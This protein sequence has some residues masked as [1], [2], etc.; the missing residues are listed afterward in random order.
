M[1]V[2]RLF[3]YW[4]F[5]AVLVLPAW[6]LVGASV[7]G[8]SGWMVVG[9]FF[10]GVLLGIGLL[11]VA[12]L[13]YARK[14]V[15]TRRAVSWADVGALT[16]WHALI[17]ALGFTA[18]SGGLPVLIVVVG[19]AAFWFVIWEFYSA[20]RARMREMFVVIDE[21]ARF[22][23]AAAGGAAKAPRFD[24]TADPAVIVIHEKPAER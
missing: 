23:S 16:L 19:L 4:Q 3:Y 2:R 15:R 20:A 7:F 24:S 14:D 5:I 18:R 1:F 12:L 22:G 6:L 10:G 9:S 8:A 13:I 11:L 21:T 17:V